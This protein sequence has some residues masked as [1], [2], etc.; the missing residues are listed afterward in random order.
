MAPINL[1]RIQYWINQGRLDPTQPI[2][3]KELANSRCVHGVKDGVITDP[4]ACEFRPETL[5]CGEK[6]SKNCLTALQVEALRKLYSPLYG[7][8]GERE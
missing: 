5:I 1:N 2:T 8:D 7:L 6:G 3:L 4:D